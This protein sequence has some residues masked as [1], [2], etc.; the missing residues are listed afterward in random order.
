[1]KSP[2]SLLIKFGEKEHLESML[3][4]GNIHC[5]SI[6]WCA[7]HEDGNL[8]GDGFE[9]V[10]KTQFLEN[11]E[12]HLK[13]AGNSK[14]EWMRL[15]VK[16]ALYKEYHKEPIG[17]LFC[18]SMFPVSEGIFRIDEKCNRFGGYLLFIHNQVEF[19]R[20]IDDA[21]TT[22]GIDFCC[23]EINYLNLHKHTGEK[24][25]FQKD[26]EYSFQHEYRFHLHTSFTDTFEFSIGN[27]EDIAVLF[28]YNYVKGFMVRKQDNIY[29]CCPLVEAQ[30]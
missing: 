10:I 21:L 26:T 4:D 9:A 8:R 22:L 1:M 20:R 15:N 28:D 27:I 30:Y 11:P 29:Q 12:I 5:K 18:M 17:N 6:K 23:G 24:K 14:S 13:E 25:L 2:L 7:E 3:K 19:F 16:T